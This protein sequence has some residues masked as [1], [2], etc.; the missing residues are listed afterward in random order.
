[1]ISFFA[2]AC[3]AAPT[4]SPTLQEIPSPTQPAAITPSPT[5]EG[6]LK[7]YY[8]ENAQVELIGPDGTRVLIDV[9]N[10]SALSSPATDRDILLTTHSHGDHV[11]AEFQGSFPGRQLFIQSG[12]IDLVDSAIRGIPSGHN[13]SDS[14]KPEGGTNYIYLI[15]LGGLRIAHFGDIGQD[16][17]TADQLA[18][19]GKVDVAITQFNNSYSNMNVENRKGFNLMDQLKPRLIIPTHNSLDAAKIAAAKWPALYASQRFVSIGRS[20][21]TEETRILFLGTVAQSYA[22]LVGAK[23]V[24]W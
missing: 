9:Y 16:A 17:L 20:D 21:L 1:M 10:P 12:S 3:T 4:S 15:E 5:E 8:E 2:A 22:I 6:K 23:Q 24:D 19:L 7:I 18:A 11:N 14:F 13:A